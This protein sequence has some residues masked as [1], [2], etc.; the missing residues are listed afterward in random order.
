MKKLNTQPIHSMFRNG[1]LPLYLLLPKFKVQTKSNNSGQFFGAKKA[2]NSH[3]LKIALT[4]GF[5]SVIGIILILLM[6]L[7]GFMQ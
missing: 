3:L 4:S 7:F 6:L 2:T 1:S 5:I